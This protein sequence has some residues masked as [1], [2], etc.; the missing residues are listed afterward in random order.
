MRCLVAIPSKGRPENIKKIIL[1]F[2][3]RLGLDYKIFV[4][5]GDSHSYNYENVIVHDENDIGLGG[6]LVSVKRYAIQNQYDIILKL[7][8]DVSGIGEIENDLDKIF[9]AFKIPQVSA[10]CFPYNFEFYAKTPKL[11][12]RENKRIQTAYFIR[13][14]KFRPS[15]EVNTFEDFYQFLQIINNNEKTLYCSRHL[16]NCEQVGKGKGGLQL[17][18]RSEMAKKEIQIF[19]SIDPSIS[20]I[21]KP[22]KSWK[23]EPKFTDKKYRSKAI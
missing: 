6:A 15:K 18:D 7:D 13:A 11:F 22:N 1:P 23:Y 16:I 4:E 19:K 20:V 17:F 21:S 12:T 3:K 5:P 9:S 2:V 10:I 14:D 8:D